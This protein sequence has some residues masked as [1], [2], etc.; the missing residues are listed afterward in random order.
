VA[1]KKQKLETHRSDLTLMQEREELHSLGAEV[2]NF[3]KKIDN[4]AQSTEKFKS[5]IKD[6]ATPTLSQNFMSLA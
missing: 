3:D 2:E 5:R 4:A 6:A 1:E